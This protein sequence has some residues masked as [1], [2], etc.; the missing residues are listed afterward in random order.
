MN[1]MG[2]V[3]PAIDRGGEISHNK[4]YD[5]PAIKGDGN[6]YRGDQGM[7]Q[8]KTKF[9]I[10]PLIEPHSSECDDGQKGGSRKRNL[11]K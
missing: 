11:R 5:A 7:G 4:A 8:K 6:T 9:N 3:G 2:P 1:R 10:S